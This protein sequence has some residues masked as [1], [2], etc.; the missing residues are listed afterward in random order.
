[1]VEPDFLNDIWEHLVKEGKGDGVRDK[2]GEG[3]GYESRGIQ[4]TRKGGG[5]LL[6]V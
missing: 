2:E 5:G 4:R 6:I 1:M 3:E